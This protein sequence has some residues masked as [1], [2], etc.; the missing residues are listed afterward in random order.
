MSVDA[1][2]YMPIVGIPK[3]RGYRIVLTISVI[4]NI[5][6]ASALYLYSTVEGF[7]SVIGAAVGY[8]G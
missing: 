2:P 8:L 3:H 1:T 6:L 7:M 4:L 5:V